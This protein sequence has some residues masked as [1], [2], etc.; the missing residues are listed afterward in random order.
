LVITT[1]PLPGRQQHHQR[2]FVSDIQ[3]FV[4][5]ADEL[6]QA[7][8]QSH[9]LFVPK[10]NQ[11]INPRRAAGGPPARGQHHY[12][13]QGCHHWSNALTPKSKLFIKRVSP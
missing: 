11:R 3:A 7:Q 10:R 9:K 1:A 6:N 4:T 8:M 12:G 5:K 2:A 13:E